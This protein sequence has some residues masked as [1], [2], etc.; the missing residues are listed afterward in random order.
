MAMRGQPSRAKR[1]SA[2][3]TWAQ[4]TLRIHVEGDGVCDYCALHYAS[5]KPWP[6]LPAQVALFYALSPDR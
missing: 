6:C 1:L 5:A 2:R 4:E 3:R